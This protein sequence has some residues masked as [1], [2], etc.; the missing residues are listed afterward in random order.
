MDDPPPPPGPP[1]WPGSEPP[2]EPPP[3]T[4]DGPDR[5]DPDRP[6]PDRPDPVRLAPRRGEPDPAWPETDLRHDAGSADEAFPPGLGLL[7]AVGLAVWSIVSQV[8]VGSLATAGGI[9]LAAL[10][11]VTLLG[12]VAVIQVVTLVGVLAWVRV[13]GRSLWR[14]FG[15][16]RPRWSHVFM[17]VGLGLTG[18]L[19]VQVA[20]A[21][22]LSA[23]PDAPPPSQ[24]VLQAQGAWP[25]L[26]MQVVTAVV[27][28]PIA[29]ELVHR[30][31][32]FQAGRR[33][34]GLVGGMVFS[35]LLFAAL[36]LEVWGSPQ[37]ML[38]LLV[39]GL[40]LAAIFHR[41]GSLVV[42]IMAHATFN[43]VTL[44]LAAIAPSLAS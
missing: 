27:L 8:L 32:V 5:P 15:P 19:L 17:G 34:F 44:A 20:A 40:W 10:E 11:G 3:R 24:E 39:L 33:A 30:G 12:V 26:V 14:L 41:T 18:L 6:G 22:V 23:L 31:A 7:A 28:A 4:P 35:A 42:P 21:L 25:V 2:S 1:T 16:V 36:H 9:D 37:A 43:G 13:S 29:E 38:G